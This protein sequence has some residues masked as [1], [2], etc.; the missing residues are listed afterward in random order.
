VDNL[1]GLNVAAA[2]EFFDSDKDGYVDRSEFER[3]L[4]QLGMFGANG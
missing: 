4:M 1:R 3:A 2:F